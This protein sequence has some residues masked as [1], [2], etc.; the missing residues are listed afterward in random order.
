MRHIEAYQPLFDHLLRE[1]GLILLQSEMDEIIR[2]VKEMKKC[3][4]T[5]ELI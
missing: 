4:R 3:N 1:H 5:I 2:I